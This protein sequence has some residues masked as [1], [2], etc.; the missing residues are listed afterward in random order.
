[1]YSVEDL[2]ISH[3][4]KLPKQS[5][6]G[7]SVRPAPSASPPSYSRHQQLLER[8]RTVNGYC[9]YT[10]HSSHPRERSQSRQERPVSD[11]GFCDANRSLQLQAKDVSYWRRKAQDFA[12]L[13]DYTGYK[14]AA[15]GGRQGSYVRPERAEEVRGP[16]PVEECPR[17]E[18]PRCRESQQ[19][20]PWRTTER[21]CQSLGAEEWHPAGEQR[22]LSRTPEGMVLPRTKAKTQSLPRMQ[23]NCRQYVPLFHQSTY[24]AP[25]CPDSGRPASANQ[26]SIT[27]K[28][29]FTRPPRPPSYEM[30]QQIRGSCELLSGR[31]S[32]RT[33]LPRLRTAESQLEYFAQDCGP[34]GY[35]P[36]PS[37]KRAP[38]ME[39]VCRD[40]GEVAI[41]YRYRGDVYQQLHRAPDGSHWCHPQAGACSST[42]HSRQLYPVY[43]T[44]DRPGARVQYIPFDHSS[45]LGG[46]SLTDSDKIRHIR[47]ELPSL[48]VS[49]PA[50]GNSAFLP[51]PLGPSLVGNLVNDSNPVYRE[52][53]GDSSRWHRHLHKETVD[54][55]PANDQNYNNR[56]H[57]NQHGRPTSPFSA[58]HVPASSTGLRCK[59]EQGFLETITQVKQIRPDFG[60]DNN[61]NPKRRFSETIFCLVSVPVHT[62]SNLNKNAP[63]D[64]NN[65]ETTSHSIPDTFAVGLKE[66]RPMRSRSVNQVP[67]W[68][69]YS[70]FD[71]SGTSSLRNYKRA[72]LR[73]EI[74]DAWALQAN[75]SKELYSRSWPGHQY[76]NQETQTGS[77][78]V[79]SPEPE[80]KPTQAASG[81]GADTTS[82]NGYLFKDQKN[83]HLSSNSAFSPLNPTQAP[84][85]KASFAELVSPSKEPVSC[86]APNS[87][88]PPADS[89]EQVSFGQFLLKPV[90]RRP[91]DVI[92]ALESIN[93]EM[94]ATISKRAGM[95]VSRKG[96]KKHNIHRSG[97][98]SLEDVHL[99]KPSYINVRS[100]S[101]TSAADMDLERNC[102]FFTPRKKRISP[103]QEHTDFTEDGEVT[104]QDI[105]VPQESMLRDVGLKV[106]TETAPTEPT[107]R[108]CSV[109][110]FQPLDELVWETVS[111][112]GSQEHKIHKEPRAKSS[113]KH[114]TSGVSLR[115]CR[116]RSESSRSSHKRECS[117]HVNKLNR[118]GSCPNNNEASVADEHLENLLIQ[119]KTNSLPAE[120]FSHLYEVKCAEGIPENES[121][122]QRAARILGIAVPV[123]AL[124]VEKAEEVQESKPEVEENLEKGSSKCHPSVS[125]AHDPEPTENT[126]SDEDTQKVPL[127]ASCVEKVEAIQDGSESKVEEEDPSNGITSLRRE[128]FVEPS[129]KMCNDKTT[130]DVVGDVL[131]EGA[132]C[133]EKVEEIQDGVGAKVE[134]NEG[135]IENCTS[136]SEDLCFEPR[137]SICCKEAT[138]QVPVEAEA[139]DV[140]ESNVE[141]EFTPGAHNLE[142]A[143]N[144]CNEETTQQIQ[145][146]PREGQSLSAEVCPDCSTGNTSRE[147]DAVKESQS[148]ELLEEG[149]MFREEEKPNGKVA[150]RARQDKPEERQAMEAK[151][152][153]LIALVDDEGIR[154][155]AEDLKKVESKVT[156]CLE[157]EGPEM[158]AATEG[159]NSRVGS[160]KPPKPKQRMKLQK[161]ALLPKPRCVPKR[162]IRLPGHSSTSTTSTEAHTRSDIPENYDPSRVERV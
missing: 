2:L 11:I 63:A 139:R 117:P 115:I 143:G 49:E 154:E 53:E 1:M 26:L 101:F 95:S 153:I 109:P 80:D 82:T 145:D 103:T 17:S 10:L 55:T 7:P 12:V 69:Q 151:E 23:T 54:N 144:I 13:L 123:G 39:G 140:G 72:P 68:S 25:R 45:A 44:H 31:D 21:K 98:Q 84:S 111:T 52:F 157:K 94:E 147:E 8:P 159:E 120:D 42:A 133:I 79:K 48:T 37:Y 114:H 56:Y 150:I 58:F 91:C 83:L 30:H 67:I 124:S 75:D 90:D 97:V 136:V 107:P 34:P 93:K 41:N 6:S 113:H 57:K 155:V 51:P 106:Y 108:S 135:G 62:P 24:R 20:L 27:P 130:Q 87:P 149:T 89:T 9:S 126:G 64:Q 141:E 46:N 14:E 5:S 73:K 132:L 29:R 22:L 146:S 128:H 121:I 66:S 15:G 152:E 85:E 161:P 129:E 47:K 81:T 43:V 19:L 102:S 61:K 116:S 77:P 71:T 122:E 127:G 158:N 148:E 125:T 36:P 156:G 99:E 105:P 78:L 137:E 60:S 100:K 70:T 38:I 50:S 112:K 76:R 110:P 162:E 33:P 4:Y 142:P 86:P 65:N 74:I 138:Q 16:G 119:E 88:A 28:P 35:I 32:V 40:Y 131:Q 134:K 160:A 96:R 59:S 104:Q 92:G 18:R 118:V 3:G